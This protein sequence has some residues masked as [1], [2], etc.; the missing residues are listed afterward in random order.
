[1]I[2]DSNSAENFTFRL[3]F[4]KMTLLFSNDFTSFV[5]NRRFKFGF[6]SS[7]YLSPLI[8]CLVS[9]CYR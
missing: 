9:M 3:V 7:C 5:E 4:M 6:T 1:M 8:G 2:E